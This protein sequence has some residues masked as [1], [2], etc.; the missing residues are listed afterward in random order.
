MAASARGALGFRFGG[1]E[2]RG[3]QCVVLRAQVD[4]LRVVRRAAV[5]PLLVAHEL[6][7]AL[8]LLDVAHAHLELVRHPCVGAALPHPGADLVEVR[9]Q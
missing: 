3:D 7:L 2:L 6:V 5:R 9:A 1:L 4:L 8:E